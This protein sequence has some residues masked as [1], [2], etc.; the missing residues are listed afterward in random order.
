MAETKRYYLAQFVIDSV[1]E[2]IRC[3]EFTVTFE[4][5]A[6]ERTATN[7]HNSYDVDYGH[8]TITWSCD[9]VDPAFRK[10]LK[11]IWIEQMAGAPRFTVATFD[12]NKS[13]GELESDDVLYDC[14]IT[15]IEKTSANKPFSIEG[16]CLHYKR[17]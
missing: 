3:N 17:D 10:D 12:F 6:E 7:S 13:T 15:N 11:R 5:D 4:M 14:Y 2:D 1:D 16:G 8:E 9:E